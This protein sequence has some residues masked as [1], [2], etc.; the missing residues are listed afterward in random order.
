MVG[1]NRYSFEQGGKA[2]PARIVAIVL[3]VALATS[4]TAQETQQNCEERCILTR[5]IDPIGLFEALSA[6]RQPLADR[7]A[8]RV[9]STGPCPGS[10]C[11][12]A[13]ITAAGETG[14]EDMTGSRSVLSFTAV[15]QRDLRRVGLL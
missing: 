9:D 8:A 12:A 7:I 4:A 5:L 3:A 11:P 15:L 13:T 1:K 10:G 2:K 14:I 6:S